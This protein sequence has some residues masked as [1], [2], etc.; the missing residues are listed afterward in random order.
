MTATTTPAWDTSGKSWVEWNI[1]TCTSIKL[2]GT[3][4]PPNTNDINGVSND[5]CYTMSI[6]T[7]PTLTR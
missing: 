2:T 4:E 1:N 5:G 7:N 3:N 6:A